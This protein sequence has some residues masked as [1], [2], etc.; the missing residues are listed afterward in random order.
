MKPTDRSYPGDSKSYSQ[1]TD[2]G[3]VTSKGEGCKYGGTQVSSGK[4]RIDATMDTCR[5]S[6]NDLISAKSGISAGDNYSSYN[7]G[8]YP[9][10]NSNGSYGYSG[11]DSDDEEYN[12]NKAFVS[13]NSINKIDQKALSDLNKPENKDRK[14][15][16]DYMFHLHYQHT[17][18]PKHGAFS[19]I[20]KAHQYGINKGCD[21]FVN[22]IEG[23]VCQGVNDSSHEYHFVFAAAHK[24]ALDNNQ[25]K[26][27]HEKEIIETKQSSSIQEQEKQKSDRWAK[28]YMDSLVN[29]GGSDSSHPAYYL[30]S[31]A[32]SYALG[33]STDTNKSFFAHYMD[34]LVNQGAGNPQHPHYYMLA[35][36]HTYAL[37]NQ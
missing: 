34:S 1:I 33:K 22:F 13:F 28:N 35:N 9:T 2:K 20:E 6:V 16:Y 37:K 25:N 15:A 4:A 11:Y 27:P 7:K 29:Q 18:D 8:G 3:Y 31:N 24:Y 32:Y 23:L 5:Y 12:I 19:S 36:A 30:F 10:G 14:W 17:N 26:L 21:N